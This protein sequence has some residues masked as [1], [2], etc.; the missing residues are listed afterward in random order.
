[1]RPRSADRGVGH[2]SQSDFHHGRRGCDCRGRVGYEQGVY[3]LSGALCPPSGIR[4]SKEG[5]LAQPERQQGA[6]R[7]VLPR[8][9]GHADVRHSVRMVCCAGAAGSLIARLA[10]DRHRGQRGLQR[11][12]LPQ[13]LWLHRRY[14]R[15][16]QQSAPNRLRPR[17]PHSAGQWRAVAEP[18]DPGS[19]DRYRADMR[20]LPY[21][22]L[23]L[24]GA[25]PS[26]STAQER[27]PT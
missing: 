8:R 15:C 3:A 11:P 13:S 14:D 26:S 10:H 21:G 6:A 4:R 24:Q 27:S 7:L 25:P 9:P 12:G 20:G 17:R 2:A 18:A 1:L 16:R 22:P 23:H 19:H 5:R